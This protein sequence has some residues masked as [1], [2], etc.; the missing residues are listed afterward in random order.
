[1][2]TMDYC[3]FFE[4]FGGSARTKNL[5]RVAP[6]DSVAATDAVD[7]SN[8]LG[9]PVF[10]LPRV[11]GLPMEFIRLCPWEMEFLYMVARRAKVG[12]VEIGRYNGGST[13]LLACAA[14][15][16][17]IHSIDIAPQNDDLLK[18]LFATH[19]VGRNVTLIVGDSQH[20]HYD[21]VGPI[22]VLFIDGD[23]SYDGC[24][25]DIR[26]WYD[27]VIPGGM[28]VFHDSYI[29]SPA[30]GVQ[31]A[32]LDLLAEKQEE[33]QVIVSPLIGTAHWRYPHGSMACLQKKR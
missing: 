17:P 1:M 22:D 11:S 28:I 5:R 30:Y 18:E 7:G 25:A 32:I 8:D 19:E 21:S 16:V 13:F 20:T 15:G 12:I 29:A 10:P 14:P 23:H 6:D 31:D 2:G 33:L 3:E 24:M 4:R 27:T 9:K 26:N